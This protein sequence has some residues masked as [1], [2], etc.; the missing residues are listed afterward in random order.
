[1]NSDKMFDIHRRMDMKD[2]RLWMW[3]TR[4]PRIGIAKQRYLLEIFKTPER[5]WNSSEE[6][7]R[8]CSRLSQRD[9]TS[10]IQS[11]NPNKIQK[12]LEELKNKNIQFYSM[13]H[14]CYPTLLKKIYDPPY[15]I[16]AK[17]KKSLIEET[18]ISI[19][20]ARR[21]SEY[22][23]QMAF[24]MGK[25]L[26]SRGIT[27]VSGM[28][29]GVDSASHKGTLAGKGRTVAV[30]GSGV[31]IC[32]P[33]EN[34][35]LYEEIIEQGVVLSEFPPGTMPKPA[36]FPMRNRIISGLSQG[37]LIVEAAHRSGSL[38]TADQALEQGRDVYAIPGNITSSLSQGTNH[39]IQQGAKLVM[40]V[41]DIL[42]DIDTQLFDFTESK[43]EVFEKDQG[44][45][46]EKE[47]KIV[48]DCLSLDP[49]SI[50]QLCQKTGHSPGMLQ[51]ILLVLELKGRVKK[52]SSQWFVRN[53]N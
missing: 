15:V 39:L 24:Y 8:S 9:I 44:S 41:E 10:I 13:D 14:P 52:V 34:K 11:K 45:P 27:V 37:I 18:T 28:A 29:R 7:L 36:F 38:I 20:G 43:K 21:C 16:Y 53:E 23:R 35:K 48:Y 22:G 26:G 47:E 5:I 6:E 25:E 30:L 3:F 32:Y 42:E 33:A 46:L 2:E 51:H 12:W 31:D 40:K 4:I 1:M 49:I 50:D 17:G 19:V